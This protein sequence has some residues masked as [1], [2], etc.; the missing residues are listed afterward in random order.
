M[1]VAP[2]RIF[3]AQLKCKRWWWWRRCW[4]RLRW[5]GR[6]DGTSMSCDD[7]C[8]CLL[9]DVFA[10]KFQVQIM[11]SAVCWTFCVHWF[12]RQRIPRI[13]GYLCI[14]VKQMSLQDF[15]QFKWNVC[16]CL[17][18]FYSLSRKSYCFAKAFKAI[19]LCVVWIDFNHFVCNVVSVYIRVSIS[20]CFFFFLFFWKGF[21][22]CKRNCVRMV[23]LSVLCKFS[24]VYFVC[25]KQIYVVVVFVVYRWRCKYA[26]VTNNRD[27]QSGDKKIYTQTSVVNIYWYYF[28]IYRNNRFL[29]IVRWGLSK[30]L[31]NYYVCI[32]IV[33]W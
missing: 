23:K 1:N 18:V 12:I 11:C 8:V 9:N 2:F 22:L 10:F 31:F 29:Q 15:N 17:Q 33:R 24:S 4:W 28:F 27:E 5:R 16:D 14:C 19:R 21:Y 20:Y 25:A 6:R 26:M 30:Y 3:S 13:W 32:Q 7:T